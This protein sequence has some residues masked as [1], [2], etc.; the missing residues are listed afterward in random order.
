MQELENYCQYLEDLTVSGD[1]INGKG[2]QKWIED[3]CNK[4][5]KQTKKQSLIESLTNTAIGFLI[6]LGST[7]IIFPLV[8][9][10][11]SVSKNI[12]VTLFFTVVSILRGYV[13]RRYFNR[14]VA[15]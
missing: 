12:I 7:F 5:M 11:S 1:T 4:Y 13:I 15:L 9:F 6:S 14:K 3:Y 8:G 2:L 10:E